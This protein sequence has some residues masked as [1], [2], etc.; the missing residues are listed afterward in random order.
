M[1]LTE[2]Q[3][4]RFYEY[5]VENR[6]VFS[7]R[8]IQDF[9]QKELNIEL[10]LKTLDGDTDSQKELEERFRKHFFR[11]RFIK[12]IVSTIKYCTIDQT[13]YN[14]KN[15]TRNQLIF[16]R[17]ASED[18][19]GTLGELLL[20]TK[21]KPESEPIFSDPVQFQTSFSN[22]VLANAFA[23]LTQKQQLIATLCYALCYQDNEIAKI[24]GV[25]PQAVCKTRN[26]AL[27]KLRL[28]MLERR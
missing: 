16:D 3:R 11:V 1:A 13:R 2:V 17:P 9:F 4:G 18:G 12:F 8:V 26:L 6:S 27:Q 22:D 25:S 7:D 28:A 23:A 20:C 24:I 21:M 5:S 15:D 19:D 10:L 14:Q